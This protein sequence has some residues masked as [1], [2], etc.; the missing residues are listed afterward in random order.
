MTK[1]E[2]TNKSTK[3]KDTTTMAKNESQETVQDENIAT[4]VRYEVKSV[5]EA[6][7]MYIERHNEAK[8]DEVI[9]FLAKAGA[10]VS[11]ATVRSQVAAARKNLGLTQPRVAAPVAEIKAAFEA[12][13]ITLAQVLE[14]LK[15]NGIDASES[16][17]RSQVTK[18]RKEAG[19][20]RKTFTVSFE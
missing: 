2:N 17:V 7:K 6:V 18:L 20:G 8:P 1:K 5:A 16:T 10:Q 19:L 15:A 3:V 9:A 13:N 14:V 12:G 11:P 4:P